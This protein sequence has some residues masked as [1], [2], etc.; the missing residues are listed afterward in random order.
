MFYDHFFYQCE[1]KLISHDSTEML[2]ISLVF[3]SEMHSSP[4][5]FH[6]KTSV[7]RICDVVFAVRLSGLWKI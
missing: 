1:I 2:S 6:K 7:M 3:A 5:I 4:V